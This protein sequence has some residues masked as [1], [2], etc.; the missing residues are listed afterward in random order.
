[1]ARFVGGVRDRNAQAEFLR[2][3]KQMARN[4]AATSAAGEF[5]DHGVLLGLGDDDHAQYLNAAR[6][7]AASDGHAILSL[8]NAFGVSPGADNTAAIQA[9]IDAVAGTKYA[10]YIDPD[11]YNINAV[12]SLQLRNNLHIIM[13][14]N[15]VLVAIPNDATSYAI[16]K[17]TDVSNVT[18]EGGELHGDREHHLGSTGE[19]GHG[20]SL[21]GCSHVRVRDTRVLDCWGDGVYLGASAAQTYC[22]DVL[23]DGMRVIYARRN[24]FTIITGKNITL[25]RCKAYLTTGTAPQAGFCIEPNTNG[26]FLEY[27]TLRDC[28]SEDSAT[29]GIT[30]VLQNLIG[31]TSRVSI[32]IYN[33]SCINDYA[34]VSIMPLAGT[35]DGDIFI[36]HLKTI[37]TNAYGMQVR[38]YAAT[39]PKIHVHEPSIVNPNADANAGQK[40]G[41]GLSVFRE[42]Y[43]A[44][45]AAIGNVNVVRPTV[46]DTRGSPLMVQGIYLADEK[47]GLISK[48]AILDP[49]EFV[50]VGSS[51]KLFV[52]GNCFVTDGFNQMNRATGNSDL[53][54]SFNAYASVVTNGGTS[55]ARLINLGSTTC[56]TMAGLVRIDVTNGQ[57]VR[58]VPDASSRIYPLGTGNGKSIYSNVVG[59]SVTL[60]RGGATVWFIT[61]LVGT[62]AAEP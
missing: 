19:W 28:I 20:L 59:S 3:K 4:Q 27:I 38:D 12:I 52:G 61:N 30:I 10:L 16:L 31:T 57:E 1:L 33:H 23:L 32:C 62:W 56:P 8:K 7:A 36:D 6:H 49:L 54:Y 53:N 35:L 21:L 55:G 46:K 15:T 39:G 45:T 47:S 26:Q 50:G 24:G 14:P 37:N 40:Y 9:A 29:H 41:A 43:D 11:Y 34:G 5:G 2:L 42:S 25:N 17:G 51:N 60:R 48:V 13:S 18:I 44:G 22:E 58:I